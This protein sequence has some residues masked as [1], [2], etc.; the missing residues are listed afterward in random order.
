MYDSSNIID[1]HELFNVGNAEIPFEKEIHLVRIDG[2]L[3]PVR[4]IFDDGAMVNVIDA[5]VFA[6]LRHHLSPCGTSHKV[7]RVANGTLVSSKGS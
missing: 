4:A 1:F 2:E 5:D 3:V 6:S 7:L